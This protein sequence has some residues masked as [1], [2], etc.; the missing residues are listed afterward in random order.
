MQIRKGF[1]LIELLVVIS[2]IALLIG[3]L[4]PALNA[5][6]SSSR[7]MQNAKQLADL[8]KGLTTYAQGNRGWF[9]GIDAGGGA[10]K[11]TSAVSAT[12]KTY[13]SPGDMQ[14]ATRM[15]ILLNGNYI[16]PDALVSPSETNPDIKPAELN[17]TVSTD[18]FSY[19]AL[20]TD[21]SF[22]SS[23]ASRFRWGE[24]SDT[25]NAQAVVMSDR[26]K[27][28][29][30]VFGDTRLSTT[31]IHVSSTSYASSTPSD[32]SGNVVWNDGH[33]TY[34]TSAKPA[35]IKLTGGSLLTTADNDDTNIF[36]TSVSTG[37]VSRVVMQYD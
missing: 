20:Y 21:D 3:I 30:N 7:R 16:A 23:G 32:W 26:N 14:V 4:L 13:G 19:S 33:A 34:L 9:A 2:I 24:W 22:N 35:A 8:Q 15:A 12:T 11:Y 10:S 29:S 17:N 37:K 27:S 25:S 31:S 6:R 18:H 5:A 36:D 1:T 28:S